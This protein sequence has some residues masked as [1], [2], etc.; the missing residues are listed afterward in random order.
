MGFVANDTVRHKRI[1]IQVKKTR[2]SIKHAIM[3]GANNS[4]LKHAW[5]QRTIFCL[6]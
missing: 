6:H 5:A 1:C 3:W 2:N 4:M